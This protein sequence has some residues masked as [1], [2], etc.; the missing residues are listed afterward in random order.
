MSAVCECHPT[1]SLNSGETAK[2]SYNPYREIYESMNKTIN[3]VLNVPSSD[4]NCKH[5]TDQCCFQIVP[6]SLH[7]A[8]NVCTIFPIVWHL[9]CTPASQVSFSIF[10][11]FNCR[12]RVFPT[13]I[14]LNYYSNSEF[15]G[16]SLF[17]LQSPR[18]SSPRQSIR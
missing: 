13:E 14:L 1:K 8:Q 9:G 12:F 17:P 18:C 15:Y 10:L 2:P 7:S 16:F 6:Y 3:L 11:L 4:W 5:V